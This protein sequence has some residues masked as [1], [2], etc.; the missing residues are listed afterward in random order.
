MAWAK[1]TR[2]NE[3]YLSVLVVGEL[4]RGVELRRRRD[5]Q[6]ADA[7]DIWLTKL[8]A[9]YSDRILPVDAQVAEEWGHMGVPDPVP[10]IDGLLAATAK[11]HGLVFVTRNV[12]DITPMG[13][14]WINPFEPG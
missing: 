2:N 3:Q 10:V 7:L 12:R 13:V 9:N 6:A 4:R 11:V 5:P 14:D 8:V 1:S